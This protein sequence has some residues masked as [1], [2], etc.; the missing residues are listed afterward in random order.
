M[1]HNVLLDL[2]DTHQHLSSSSATPLGSSSKNTTFRH[3]NQHFYHHR[4][5]WFFGM[6]KQLNVPSNFQDL[7]ILLKRIF[8]SHRWPRFI[9]FYFM[10]ILA[11]F[12]IFALFFS[13]P[14]LYSAPR[15]LV[16]N[17]NQMVND[18]QL[19][20][21]PTNQYFPSLSPQLMQQSRG[22]NY[23]N[24]FE[25]YTS[26]SEHQNSNDNQSIDISILD[27]DFSFKGSKLSPSPHR[28][29]PSIG[30]FQ[31]S[32]G[33]NHFLNLDNL[34]KTPQQTFKYDREDNRT[35]LSPYR[36]FAD[37]YSGQAIAMS[38]PSLSSSSLP[39]TFNPLLAKDFERIQPNKNQ[40]DIKE[41]MKHSWTNYKR[42]AWGYD[43]L[44]PRAKQPDQW[45]NLG[46]TIVD[47]VDTLIM[48]SL[49]EGATDA[50]N[51]IERDLDF[52][53][54]NGNANCFE[55]TIRILG[56]LLSA[57]HLEPERT[58]ILAKA[59]NLG[60]RLLHCYDTT[61]GIIPYSDIDLAENRSHAPGWYP[62]SSL[63]EVSSIQLEF[64]DLTRLTGQANFES[65]TFKTSQHLHNLTKDS[66]LL[67]MYINPNDGRMDNSNTITLGARADSYYEY[68]LKQYLQTDIS[69]L[70]EDYLRSIKEIREKLMKNTNGKL[71]LT[72]IAEVQKFRT[73]DGLEDLDNQNK[74]DHLVCFL[75]GTLILGYYHFSPKA[76]H[77][78]TR[79]G[80]HTP[81]NKLNSD[82]DHHLEMAEALSRTCYNMY[83][84]T[85]TGL[86]PEIAFFG[87][88]NDKAEYIIQ[89][90]SAHNIL[91]PEFVESLFYLY[92]ITG[93]DMY[94]HQARNVSSHSK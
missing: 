56:G 53:K 32:D 11:F 84:N 38:P 29:R 39:R 85:A 50:L 47:S 93:N 7:L 60:N 14:L 26:Q 83:S 23:N 19:A 91:R 6:N 46:L 45:F 82:Y 52:E 75:P 70:E 86:S 42:Y 41:A 79:Y 81:Q 28:S 87:L 88:L 89:E 25:H 69:W 71:N 8:W 30:R 51:W 43:M 33:I 2:A 36:S 44:K 18:D 68:L 3:Q 22:E 80:H 4:F 48:M 67:Q 9:K 16:K 10:L 54:S 24:S 63:S 76:I 58:G 35:P 40:L 49:H 21:N 37:L 17:D 62:F 57:Y 34:E 77:V 5:N 90:G 31:P 66:A 27:G 55:L 59:K 61:S 74:M 94:R 78:R 15:K 13:N 1:S 65:I 73:V 72:F 20:T 64:R 12:I 92:H